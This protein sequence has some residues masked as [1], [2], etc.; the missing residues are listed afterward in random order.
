MILDEKKCEQ[1]LSTFDYI[2]DERKSPD[3]NRRGQFKAGWRDAAERGRVYVESTLESL[4]WHNLGYRVG[5]KFGARDGSDIDEAF[6]C[7]ARH[8]ELRGRINRY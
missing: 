5:E 7:F 1:L 8:Y 4:T 2:A 6:H 3:S